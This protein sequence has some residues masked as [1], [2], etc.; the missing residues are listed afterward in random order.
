VIQAKKQ[1]VEEADVVIRKIKGKT[2][3]LINLVSGLE[4]KNEI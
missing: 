4:N 2:Q 3:N 1:D